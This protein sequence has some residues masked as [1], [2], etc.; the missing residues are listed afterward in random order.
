MKKIIKI[1]GFALS[2]VFVLF[3]AYAAYSQNSHQNTKD[4]KEAIKK[5]TVI[6]KSP[7]SVKT[8]YYT[9]PTHVK[10]RSDKAGNCPQCGVTMNKKIE[11]V[12]YACPHHIE[13]KYDD[14]G[15]CEKCGV[16]LE[17]KE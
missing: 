16:A 15:Q 1:K 6:N 10:V 14:K 9:C 2:I 5:D 4:K 12:Y 13:V 8:V 3:S 17:Q 7:H 11:K